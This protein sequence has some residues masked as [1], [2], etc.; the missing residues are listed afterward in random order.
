[1]LLNDPLL[2][3]LLL[4]FCQKFYGLTLS[5]LFHKT[6]LTIQLWAGCG[7]YDVVN[8]QRKEYRFK[9]YFFELMDFELE[10]SGNHAQRRIP[11]TKK[12][13]WYISLKGYFLPRTWSD[14]ILYGGEMPCLDVLPV[15]RPNASIGSR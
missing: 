14:R 2:K 6:N 12:P 7:M 10:M 3:L 8:K 1:V 11:V 5:N 15:A 13:G 9:Q 4:H